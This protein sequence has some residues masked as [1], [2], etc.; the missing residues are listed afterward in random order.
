MA[1][2]AGLDLAAARD[3]GR[4]VAMTTAIKL[5]ALP[6]ATLILCAVFGVDGL[7]A[8]VSVMYASLPG[9]ATSYVMARQM[10]GDSTL[11]AGIITATTIAAMAALPAWVGVVG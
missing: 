6:L 3:H 4:F 9:S 7:A 1:V 10:G 11:M 2:G 5:G 8:T